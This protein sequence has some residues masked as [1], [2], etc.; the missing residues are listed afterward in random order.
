ML[1][2]LFL[3]AVCAA[4]QFRPLRPSEDNFYQAPANLSSYENGD[5]IKFRPAPALIRS[6][7]FPANVK[8]AWQL[9]VRSEDS[10]GVPNA[11]VTTI[12]EP[13]DSD[14]D[15]LV[16]YQVAQDASTQNCSPSYSFLFN[17][18]M[19]TLMVQLE[20]FLMQ[21]ALAKG[22]FVVVP[23]YEGPQGAFTAGKQ[24]GHA[25][26]NSVRA[27]L[28]SG[29]FTGISNSAK[30]ALWGY[31][32]GSLASGWAAALQPTYAPELKENLVGAALGGWVTDIQ[33]SAEA[34]DGQMFSGFIPN[35]IN[36]LLNEYSEVDQILVEQ[37]ADGRKPAFDAATENCLLPSLL[38]YG[39]ENFFTGNDPWFKNGL[40]FFEIP[41]IREIIDNNTLALKEDGPVPEIPLFVF[42]GAVDEIVP[43]L[44]AVRGY[45]N[46]CKWGAKSI[47]FTVS[48]L[49]GHILEWVAG[50]GAALTWLE[51]M[52]NGETPVRGCQ[53]TYRSSNILYP[54]ADVQYH[55]LLRTS[56]SSLA[57]GRL[58]ETTRNITRSNLLSFVV[59]QA[60]GAALRAAGPIP[61]KRDLAESR[62]FKGVDELIWRVFSQLGP[63]KELFDS[64]F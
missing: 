32:G 7:Y 25:T 33:L 10:H 54:G 17:A 11:I 44:G 20:M 40:D 5:I 28:K 59:Q 18:P 35:A 49:T 4:Q 55:Q 14:P 48:N 46:F 22:W 29:N 24:A 1:F 39:Y 26:L 9:L 23:D 15:K 41:E 37:L 38:T 3:L 30:A 64:I 51:R 36:G 45:E 62:E 2:I 57:G 63:L 61:F 6:V 50:S 42:H 27:A 34:I 52:L 47:E 19:L 53:K 21:G 31:S 8:S 60:V 12:L 56:L 13:Y 58:G 43:L 16:S